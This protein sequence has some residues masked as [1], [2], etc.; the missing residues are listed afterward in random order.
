MVKRDR[1]N[2]RMSRTRCTLLIVC[3]FGGTP[4]WIAVIAQVFAH[5]GW[6]ID[7]LATIAPQLT[8][9]TSP[10]FAIAIAARFWKTGALF[11]VV[12][13]VSLSLFVPGRAP[14]IHEDHPGTVRVLTINALGMNPTPHQVVDMIADSQADVVTIVECSWQLWTLLQSDDRILARY[15]FGSGPAHP[16]EWSRIKLS[17]WPLRLIE[18]DKDKRWDVLKWNYLFRRSHIVESP[19]GEFVIGTF[20]VRSP[21]T[22]DRWREGNDQ[23]EENC[24]VIR[25]YLTPLGLPI[26]IG[27]DLNATPS[28]ARTDT[29]RKLS[30]LCRTKPANSL[31]GTWPARYPP[32]ARVAIDDVLVSGGVHSRGWRTVE[33]QTGSDHV[34]V[35]V[36]LWIP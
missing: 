11:A 24:M 20:V 35:E 10:F 36:E 19:H 15:P 3:W 31:R 14:G 22:A 5:T 2:K 30:G 34:G 8:L 6:W 32:W 21:R 12:T 33:Q 1:H 13:A 29:L 9:V 28:N 17:K 27:A 16:K 7:Q 23:L 18:L 26:V 25:E 4:A